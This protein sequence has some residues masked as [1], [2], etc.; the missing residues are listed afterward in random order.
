MIRLTWAV[1]SVTCSCID[2]ST[3]TGGSAIAGTYSDRTSTSLDTS[4]AWSITFSP[5]AVIIP[6]TIDCKFL[7]M[8]NQPCSSI[9]Y[10]ALPG[11]AGWEQGRLSTASPWHS[12]PPFRGLC[13]TI[14]FLCWVPDPQLTEQRLHSPNPD[15]RQLIGPKSIGWS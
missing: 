12:M 1:L 8:K 6:F 10:R 11:Q 4:T 3:S 2:F 9:H 15:Q 7:V 13:N 5:I 14:R